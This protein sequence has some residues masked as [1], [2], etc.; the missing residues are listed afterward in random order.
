MNHVTKCHCR[1]HRWQ[2]KNK[3]AAD[4]TQVSNFNMPTHTIHL[5]FHF[6]R[7]LRSTHFI[8]SIQIFRFF[9]LDSLLVSCTLSFLFKYRTFVFPILARSGTRIKGYKYATTAKYQQNSRGYDNQVDSSP[10][11][12]DCVR[13]QACNRNL[14]FRSP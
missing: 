13:A 4:M 11:Y 6:S 5:N 9:A 14:G 8:I 1:T 7:K 3:V 10:R 2:S 12:V